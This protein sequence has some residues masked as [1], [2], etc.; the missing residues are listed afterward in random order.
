MLNA[1]IY[2]MC[3]LLNLARLE[4]EIYIYI[5]YV[6]VPEGG[7]GFCFFSGR[8]RGSERSSYDCGGILYI[9]FSIKI[10]LAAN[11]YLHILEMLY[12]KFFLHADLCVS[13]FVPCIMYRVISVA[14]YFSLI[15]I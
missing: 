5:I 9:K 12:F 15:R 11:G 3:G 8:V 6:C 7:F 2:Y 14:K 13:L 1:A 10:I 4:V